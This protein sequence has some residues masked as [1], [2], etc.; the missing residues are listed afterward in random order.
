MRALSM[1]TG[2]EILGAGV[3][4]S[5]KY[6]SENRLGWEDFEIA[7]AYLKRAEGSRGHP[8]TYPDSLKKFRL[9]IFL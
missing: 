1:G 8:W 5:L 9:S 6:S 3:S 4:I 7:E 2:P